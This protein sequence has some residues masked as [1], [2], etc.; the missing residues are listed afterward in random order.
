MGHDM[1]NGSCIIG[2][3]AKRIRHGSYA[4]VYLD[5]KGGGKKY[6]RA[7]IQTI[8]AGGVV[9]LRKWFREREDAVAW[10]GRAYYYR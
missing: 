6:W 10:L 1:R 5:N 3:G 7:E 2:S 8:N 4:V 9:R